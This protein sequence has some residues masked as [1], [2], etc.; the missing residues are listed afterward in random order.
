MFP[1]I[2][3]RAGWKCNSITSTLYSPTYNPISGSGKYII[4][5]TA[6]SAA[7]SYAKCKNMN[8]V[9]IQPLET[10]T[11]FYDL[12]KKYEIALASTANNIWVFSLKYFT[13]SR[14]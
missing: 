6:V 11:D 10:N 12:I 7:D 13:Y 4:Y 9:R 2:L 3:N 1:F 5:K 8:G 14:I